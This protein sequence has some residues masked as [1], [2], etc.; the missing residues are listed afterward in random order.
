[1]HCES[2]NG[3]KLNVNTQH[4]WLRVCISQYI[5]LWI[6]SSQLIQECQQFVYRVDI[7]VVRLSA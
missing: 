5:V 7:L 1:M 4:D 3:T 6:S 2:C